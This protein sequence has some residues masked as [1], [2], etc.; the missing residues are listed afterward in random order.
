MRVM[1]NSTGNSV[2]S[3]RLALPQRLLGALALVQL[4]DL[5]A[6]HRQRQT[7]RRPDRHGTGVDRSQR[8]T[9]ST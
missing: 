6:D 2:P 8:Q 7:A 4:A 3:A 1:D 9:K 5:A